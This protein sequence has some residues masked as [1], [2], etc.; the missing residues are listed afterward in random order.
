MPNTPVVV[1]NGV[2][3][4]CRN[5]TVGEEDKGVLEHMLSSVGL[6]IEMPRALYGYHNRTHWLWTLLCM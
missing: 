1:R 6:G 2:T 4:Y 3:V 5:G